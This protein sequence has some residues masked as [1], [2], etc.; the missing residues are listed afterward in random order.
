M[1]NL[2][3]ILPLTTLC[4]FLGNSLFAQTIPITGPDFGPS[5][6][7]PCAS[8]NDGSVINFEDNGGAGN[9]SANA[10]DTITICPDLPNGPKII[11][12]F[13]T[14]IGFTFDID[15][16]D[17]LYIFDGPDVNSPLLGAINNG[18]NPTGGSFQ[19]SFENNTSG[20]LTLVFH[21]DGA[22]EGTGWGANIS[23]GNPAQ[24]FY[25][26][27]E[28]FINGQGANVLN[29]ID[30]GYVDMCFGDSVLLVAKPLFPYSLE[31]NGIGYSQNL[32][33]TTYD[34]E[35]SN[36]TTGPNND[37]VWF[38]PPARNGYFVD[39]KLNDIFPQLERIT[40]KI[41]VSQLPSFVGTGPLKDT[42]C[43]HEQ[44]V[45]IGGTTVT[46]TVGVTIPPGTFAVGGSVAGLTPLPDGTGI[47]Y[48]TTIPMSGFAP[49]A[50][51]TNASDLQSVCMNIEHSYLG[52]LDIWLVC[53]NGTEVGLVNSYVAGHLPGGFGG[54]GTYLG[55][56]NDNGNGT[57]GIGWDY[58]FSTVNATLGNMG[59]ELGLGYTLPATSFPPASGNAMNP[60]GIYQPA[61]T[62]A[63]FAGC[64]LN[65]NWSIY[66]QDNQGIDDG[67]I[68][69]W[70]IT[71][72]ASLFPNNESYQNYISSNF[73]SPDPTI[74]SGQNDTLIIVQPNIPG[75]YDYTFNVV[76]NFGCPYDTIVKIT[77][78]DSINLNLPNEICTLQYTMTQ[79]L[80]TNDGVWTYYASAGTPTF[81]A[82]NVNTVVNFSDFGTYHLVYSDTSCS[83]A[84]TATIT[85]QQPKP[86][87]FKSDFFIC[88]NETS[89]HITFDDSLNV[90][91]YH[92]GLVNPAYDTLFHANLLAGTY[93]AHYT[94][95]LGCSKDTTFTIGFEP[96]VV[97]GAYGL[98]CNDTLI[99]TNNSGPSGTWSSPN[100]NGHVHFASNDINTTVTVDD[101][102]L[103]TLQYLD[104]VCGIATSIDVQ[105]SAYP[106]T[107]I[108]DTLVCSD[109][110]YQ[111]NALDEKQNTS[112]L[113]NTG[114]TGLSI[115]ITETGTYSITA[116]SLC[117]VMSDDAYIQ[118]INCD[119]NLPNVFTPN[120]DGTNDGF[121]L[122]EFTGLTD[123]Q[124]TIV[125]RWGNPIREFNDA[126]FIWDGKDKSGAQVAEGVYFYIAIAKSLSGKEI[127]KQGF[128]Q[129]I[130][131]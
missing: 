64:P 130:R 87:A 51:F 42:V 40:A 103:F 45:L 101:Y 116:T 81:T 35:F 128:V 25:P 29:P 33:N 30:T 7:I 122:L 37:S 79:N 13:A 100:G 113:W 88:G 117:G 94:N 22:T 97:L 98:V 26:H 5:N 127:K 112:Y 65:G 72:D 83:D 110:P 76:D 115:P 99:M 78:K 49:G 124:C 69:S 62:F 24:P 53:P 118:V 14:N 86:F 34:W 17:T 27:L 67:Y 129:V 70:E 48:H 8:Y 60:N 73:W 66:V 39:L 109:S 119:F 74:V 121:H 43:I 77:V 105:F 89:E 50:T 38:T 93:T 114:A 82:N 36:G 80:G 71:F 55:D 52:D 31:N 44:T 32:N 59:T 57:P 90:I 20:C 58:C 54:G 21:S 18:T 108:L 95:Y 104:P 75:N 28:A 2:K 85:I 131:N 46:D 61:T 56:A 6:P 120:N 1:R 102:G 106:Y 111:L 15:P 41:R 92:W 123:F 9:Y 107:Q 68:F 11:L 3:K 4:F 19:S 63:G 47:T 10:T 91:D 126:N 125:N 23:C 12:I 84:D 16:S 96:P